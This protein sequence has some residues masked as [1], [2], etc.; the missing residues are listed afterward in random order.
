M[1]TATST[2]PGKFH[3]G[4]YCNRTGHGAK[5]YRLLR[6]S[7]G[8]QRGRYVH[9]LVLEAKILGRREAFADI[10]PGQPIP[11]TVFYSLDFDTADHHNN[12]SLDNDPR[13]LHPMTNA[14][15]V[16]KRNRLVRERKQAAREQRERRR[17]EA[18]QFTSTVGF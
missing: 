7:A 6:I 10:Y 11:D 16:S 2:V 1:A 17:R 12:N 8:P 15:N 9:D 13:N 3:S 5:D 14:A 18:Q 4:T